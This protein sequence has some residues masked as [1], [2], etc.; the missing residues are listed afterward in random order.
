MRNNIRAS[1]GTTQTKKGDKT[2]SGQLWANGEFGLGYFA[3][4]EETTRAEETNWQ[5]AAG[6]EVDRQLTPEEVDSITLSDALNSHKH[7]LKGITGYG[8]RMVRNGCFLLEERLGTVDC[9]LWTFTV[10]TLGKEARGTLAKNWGK[11]TNRLVQYLSRQLGKAGRSPA[12]IGCT[13]IQTARLKKYQEGYLHLHLVCPLHSNNGGR[14][15][16]D[17]DRVRSW[18]ANALE[19]FAGMQLPTL[20]R[21]QVEQIRKS[22]E[23]YMGKYLSK[24]GSEELA[25]FIEDLGVES[26]P[27]QWW[28]SSALMRDRI[29]ETTKTGRNCGI[30]LESVIQYAFEEG[31]L[32]IFEY[33]RHVDVEVDGVLY[34]CG[35]YGK[36]RRDVAE[37][38]QEFLTS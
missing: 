26:V 29:K 7:G 27:G 6:Q 30:V 23:S 24:G 5:L 19:N 35:W 3:E 36:L 34:T 17:V 10:P 15:A 4:Y 11:L 22:A 13:E 20:P 38:L 9:A 28:F 31:N 16:L 18:F 21:V 1:I 8:K 32:E 37:D 33:I 14:F 12:I 2:P 25:A